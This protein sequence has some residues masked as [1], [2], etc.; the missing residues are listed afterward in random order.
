MDL[1]TL[2]QMLRGQSG[3]DASQD[4][5]A[6]DISQIPNSHGGSFASGLAGALK[7]G[8]TLPGDVYNGDAN[9]RLPS[10]SPDLTRVADMVGMMQAGAAA[11][12][13][14]KGEAALGSGPMFDLSR[15]REVPNVPQFDLPRNVP[16]RGVPA[17]VTD[18]VNDPGVRDKMLETIQS[19][20]EKGGDKWYNADPLREEFMNILGKDAGDAA[21]RRYQ[22][23]V[24]ATS[25]RSDVGT[26]VRNASYYYQRLMNGEGPPAV[27]DKN[28]QPYGHMAQ[29]LHQM[30][31]ERV[32]GRAGIRS[33]TQSPPPS[34]RTSSATK[35]R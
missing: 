3:P 35:P 1:A 2:V 16:P 14:A 28:P 7:S 33:T 4:P 34:W 20:V 6:I 12:G 24:A 25:P 30:N 19:G 5:S 13:A 29:R 21:F 23:M 26:N 15:L 9:I 18:L 31:V 10:E 17:R 27:G 22:N 11:G 8:A 32:A